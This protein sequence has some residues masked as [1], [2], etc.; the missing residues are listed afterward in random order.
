MDIDLK[1]G[2]L[3]C[4]W[5]WFGGREGKGKKQLTQEKWLTQRKFTGLERALWVCR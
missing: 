1:L 5:Q 3:V 4:K 2:L